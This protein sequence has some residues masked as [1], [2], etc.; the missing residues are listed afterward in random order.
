MLVSSPMD[1]PGSAPVY[2]AIFLTDQSR[3]IDG[4]GVFHKRYEVS[5]YIHGQQ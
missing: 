2:V 1:D 3:N 5:K 4:R